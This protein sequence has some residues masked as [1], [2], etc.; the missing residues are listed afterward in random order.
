MIEAIISS[1][2]FIESLLYCAYF[3]IC[4]EDDYDLF[5]IKNTILFPIVYLKEFCNKY[6][7]NKIGMIILFILCLWALFGYLFTIIL[8]I[9]VDIC[10]LI[11]KYFLI[12]FKEK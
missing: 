2:F 8:T 3:L 5:K 6:N 7:I 10:F 12:I 4:L 1:L 9:I 11:G